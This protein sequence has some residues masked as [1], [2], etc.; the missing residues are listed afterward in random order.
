[1]CKLQSFLKSQFLVHSQ[2]WGALQ[3]ALHFPTGTNHWK[4]C[5]AF[6][7]RHSCKFILHHTITRGA[8]FVQFEHTQQVN[9]EKW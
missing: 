9:A 6:G 3:K 1:M 8:V 2:T 5:D 4:N 7:S